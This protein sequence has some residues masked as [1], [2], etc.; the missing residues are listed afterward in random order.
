MANV[1]PNY[2]LVMHWKRLEILVTDITLSLS[3]S[4][5]RLSPLQKAFPQDMQMYDDGK[6]TNMSPKKSSTFKSFLYNV[7]V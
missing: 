2:V 4:H 3:V 1:L 5:G 6:C 7:V